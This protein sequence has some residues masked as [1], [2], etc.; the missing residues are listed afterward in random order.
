MVMLREH[1]GGAP[2]FA[3]FPL[4]LSSR[5]VERQQIIANPHKD[6]TKTKG[7]QVAKWL[8]RQKVDVLLLW[9]DLGIKGPSYIFSDAGGGGLDA[10]WVGDKRLGAQACLS[11]GGVLGVLRRHV[12]R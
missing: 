6:L 4:R 7:I 2:Y 10:R 12:R 8:I 3:L 5:E 1:F 9:G 11:G